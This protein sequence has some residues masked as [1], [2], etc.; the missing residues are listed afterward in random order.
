MKNISIRDVAARAGVSI[1]TVSHVINGTRNVNEPTR[2]S[3]ERA[4]E[5]LHYVPDST[6]RSFKTG[7]RNLVAF[8]VPDISNA[9]FSTMIEEVE[10]VL[11]QEGYRLLV[12]N[13]REDPQREL[14]GLNVLTSGLVDGL[15]IASAMTDYR[16]LSAAI[17][18]GFPVVLIDRQLPGAP[19]DAVYVS[20]YSAMRMGIDYLIR[21]G[22][23]KIGFL[24]GIH[25]ISTTSDRR[26]GYQDAMD[27]A[28]LS[29]EHLIRAGTSS[30]KL[31]AENLD[32]LLELGCTAL[33]ISN[34]V[35]TVEARILLGKRG[36]S[37]PKDIE[38][39]GFL[40]S[41]HAQYGLQKV[42]LIS[43][44]TAEQG[45]TAGR[46]LL[47]RMHNADAPLQNVILQAAFM[48][49]E[50]NKLIF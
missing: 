35:L 18:E 45:R 49:V 15:I 47:S 25:S 26:K 22:H 29:T 32:A 38:L 16:Q 17:P 44:P 20:S 48:P 7:K 23:Q 39:L 14:D 31:Q 36:L 1:A 46:L 10:D 9:F 30:T 5:E 3:V 37:V 2:L 33:A 19:Y 12:L 21:K 11:A 28:G 34:N 42:S 43:Q 6:A 41:D 13:T 8:V 27:A 24:T 40:D 50:Q 4:I